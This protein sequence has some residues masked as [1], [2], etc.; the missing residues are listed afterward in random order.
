MEAQLWTLVA[1][2][3]AAQLILVFHFGR[4]IDRLADRVE[5]K[6]DLLEANLCREGNA[7]T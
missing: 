4:K 5:R 7:P 3:I 2:N 6:M 1:L